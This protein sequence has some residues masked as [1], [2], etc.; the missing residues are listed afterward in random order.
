MKLRK[1]SLAS[2]LLLFV[3]VRGIHEIMSMRRDLRNR[4]LTQIQ[5]QPLYVWVGSWEAAGRS[6]GRAQCS[7][8]APPQNSS[9]TLG[10]WP[11]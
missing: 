8:L 1:L 10:K 11:H 2:A 6:G 3:T 5:S 4:V 9:G 7:I